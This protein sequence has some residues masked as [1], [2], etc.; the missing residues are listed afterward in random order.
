MAKRKQ[1]LERAARKR[2]AARQT[3]AAT[4]AKKDAQKAERKAASA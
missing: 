3:K 4:K 2:K 1:T